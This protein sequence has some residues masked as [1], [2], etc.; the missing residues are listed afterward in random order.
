MNW[1]TVQAKQSCCYEKYLDQHSRFTSQQRYMYP[2]NDMTQPH[3]HYLCLGPITTWFMS[4]K[5]KSRENSFH[6]NC[7]FIHSMKSKVFTCPDGSAIVACAKLWLWSHNHFSYEINTYF[8]KV[9]LKTY[10]AFVKWAHGYYVDIFF[11][12]AWSLRCQ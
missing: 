1:P 4:S 5:L 6:S 8:R 12:V 2:V 10:Q 9:W 11:K 7:N 3:K